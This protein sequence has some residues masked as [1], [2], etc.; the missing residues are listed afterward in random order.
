[1]L[2]NFAKLNLIALKNYFGRLAQNLS[3]LFLIVFVAVLV[4]E[5]FTLKNSWR[6]VNESR[7]EPP[8]VAKDKGVRI[9]FENYNFAV[10]K[11]ED[12]RTYEPPQSAI[13]SPF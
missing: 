8:F 2:E 10:K 7:I 11:I 6:I 1:M 9:N 13:P 12:G 3:W 4:M 5:F